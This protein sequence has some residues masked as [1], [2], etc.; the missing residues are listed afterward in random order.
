VHIFRNV[1]DFRRPVMYHWPTGPEAPQEITSVGRVAGDHGGPAWEPMWIYHNTILAGGPPRYDYGTDGLVHGM[2]HGTSR[3]VFNNIVCLTRGLPGQT[4]PPTTADFQADGNLFWSASDGASFSGEWL[5]RFRRSPAF[6]QS[7]QTYPPGWTT[8]DQFADP[9]FVKLVVDGKQPCDLR[10]RPRSPAIDAGVPLPN[11]WPDPLRESDSG[12]PDIGALPG[13]SSLWAVGVRGRMDV[14]GNL[15]TGND[16]AL[17]SRPQHIPDED[18]PTPASGLRRAAVVTGYPA[19][20]APLV[21]FALRRQ[22]VPVEVFERAWLDLAKYGDYDLVAIDGSFARAK[23]E[24][25]RFS[26]DDLVHLRRYLDGGGVL[27]LMRQRFDLFASEEGQRFLKELTGAAAP[28]PPTPIEV[29]QPAH[30][31]VN[32]LSPQ[33]DYAWLESKAAVPLRATRGESLLGS[34]SGASILHRLPVGKGELIYVGWSPAAS[35]PHGRQPSTVADE[36]VFEEQM[37]I[38]LK[39]VKDLNE[40]A[41]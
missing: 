8:H 12:T 27:M 19:F 37:A 18:P 2:G 34:D 23:V 13:G 30:P 40:P 26:A 4:L 1:F 6:E 9:E 15:L 11:N 25:S 17:Y 31:W 22:R 7:K 29:R 24:P 28:K 41:K 3:R 20:D 33:A 21:T 14:C 35:I 5:G 32:H 10:L 16:Q 38:L 39:M 36:A